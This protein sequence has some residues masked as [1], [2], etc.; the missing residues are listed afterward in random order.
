MRSVSCSLLSFPFPGSRVPHAAKTPKTEA[1]WSVRG[2]KISGR[3]HLPGKRAELPLRK[4]STEQE[5][6]TRREGM[7]NHLLLRLRC[8]P[9]VPYLRH[10]HARASKSAQ[11]APSPAAIPGIGGTTWLCVSCRT[12]VTV[13]EQSDSLSLSPS[14]SLSLPLSLSLSPL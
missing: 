12:T 14:L 3:S 10:Q 5:G 2:K 6:R 1:E 9:S 8:S 13:H 7:Q 11:P 4:G